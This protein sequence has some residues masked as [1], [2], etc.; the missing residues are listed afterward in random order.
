MELDMNNN[1]Q[2]WLQDKELA[3]RF[4]LGRSTVWVRAKIDPDFPKPKKIS[5]GLSRWHLDEIVEFEKKLKN[6]I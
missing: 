5:N 4:G 6:S 1:P 3:A 2:K